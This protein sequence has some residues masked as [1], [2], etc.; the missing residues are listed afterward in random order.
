MP[1]YT[2]QVNRLVNAPKA[3]VYETITNPELLPRWRVPE[4]MTMRIHEFEAREG[5][6]FRISLT[7]T[8]AS[9]QGKTEEHTDTYSG[10]FLDLVPGERVVEEQEFESA[11]AALRG[12]MIATYT[13]RESEGGTL[14]E[15]T[16]ENVPS[17]IP[18]KDNQMGWEMALAS[19][20]SLVEEKV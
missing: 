18:E 8:D 5:G 10:R 11:D 12:K 14:V 9:Q 4:G 20:A 16:H 6:R 2:T 19:L 7:Y 13:L 1:S 17:A 3:K 15:C